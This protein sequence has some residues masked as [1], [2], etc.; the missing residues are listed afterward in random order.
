MRRTTYKGL[1]EIIGT[2]RVCVCIFF[3]THAPF[4]VTYRERTFSRMR[5]IAIGI[6]L[7]LA[8][9]GEDKPTPKYTY[10]RDIAPIIESKCLQCHVEGGIA[11]LALDTYK[12]AHANR[13]TIQRLVTEREMPPWPPGK[14]CNE[15]VGDRSLTDD[16]I[17]IIDRWVDEDAAEGKRG[18]HPAVLTSTV[19]APTLPRIDAS[20]SMPE[21]YTPTTTPDDYRCFLL[22]WEGGDTNI[23]GIHVTPGDPEVVHHMIAFLAPPGEV[24]SF[25][26]M[27]A[28]D[29]GP[30]YTCFG[31]SGGNAMMIGGW[32]PGAVGGAFP[33]GTGL[34]IEA[35]S[36]I[37]MQ[38]H[39]NT[40][41][42]EP[43][44]VADTTTLNLMTD[45]VVEKNAVV[46]PWVK[47]TWLNG[48]MKIPADD[49]EVTHS[50]SF[51]P[52]PYMS[53]F[54]LGIPDDT[55][56]RI[57]TA[58]LHMHLRGVHGRLSIEHAD[59]TEEC[60][61]DIPHWDFHWQGDY[62]LTNSV[63]FNPGDQLRIQC[64]WDNSAENQPEFD[65]EQ[66]PSTELNW[67][68]GTTDEMCIGFM[69]VTPEL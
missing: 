28:D 33:E 42:K 14:D 2:S 44:D 56:F 9:C 22:P 32:V 15:Y 4:Q 1:E 10:Y 34:A 16:Q 23:T 41:E 46:L 68:E 39:Y 49:P 29:P 24:A 27:D 13:A 66:V 25:E 45:L 20:L 38:V 57:Y 11:P 69:Y 61:L 6:S 52:T 8:A 17:A 21:A 67:G 18:D 35:D 36:V 51:D 43:A 40:H 50:W 65:G 26:D 37:I 55:P 47:P 60:L 54:E 5:K 12:A 58:N 62:M 64:D 63:V 7:V 19:E 53:L 31:A 3:T 59:N 30:G 48:G